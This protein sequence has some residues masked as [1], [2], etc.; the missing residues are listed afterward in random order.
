M[1][2]SPHIE[3][4]RF[5]RWLAMRPGPIR[6]AHVEHRSSRRLLCTA[7]RS[8]FGSSGWLAEAMPRSRLGR[9][10]LSPHGEDDGGD[11]RILG[12]PPPTSTADDSVL[13]R[14]ISGLA[15]ADP[16][17]AWSP[18]ERYRH[19]QQD[20]RRHRARAAGQRGRHRFTRPILTVHSYLK[21]IHSSKSIRNSDVEHSFS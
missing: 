11:A 1:S 6:P 21:A 15:R 7:S 4:F 19:H 10:K 3:P 9:S 20:P 14:T 13:R 2:N 16:T 8:V 18:P 17:G 5:H 12:A